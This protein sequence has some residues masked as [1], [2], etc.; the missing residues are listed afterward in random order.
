[1]VDVHKTEKF[2][3]LYAVSAADADD[4]IP[5][6]PTLPKILVVDKSKGKGKEKE[7]RTSNKRD[8]LPIIG[9]KNQKQRY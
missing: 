3:V 6:T 1:M 8:K 2:V 7:T 9:T 4:C 5:L